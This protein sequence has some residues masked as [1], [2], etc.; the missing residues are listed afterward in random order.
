MR[1]THL[2]LTHFRSFSRLDL[3]LPIGATVIWGDN[4]A[5]K[6]NLIEALYL[7]ATSRSPYTSAEREMI[8][9][10]CPHRPAFA[11]VVGQVLR[12][13][14]VTSLEV[15]TAETD[16]S[17]S[18]AEF[19]PSP[20]PG[21]Y[22]PATVRR[23]VVING[24]P[25]QTGELLG[26]LNAV[27]FSPEE[28]ELV[29]G[30]AERRRR[31]LDIALS[32]LDRQYVRTLRQYQRVLVQRNALLRHL[33]D[34]ERAGPSQL[35]H[36]DTQAVSLGAA[37]VAARLRAVARL[38]IHLALMDGIA[39]GA[40]PI[41]I[42]YVS[43]VGFPNPAEGDAPLVQS[44]DVGD[45]LAEDV[46]CRLRVAFA[47][48]R[49]RE[50]AAAITLVGPHRDDLVVCAGA[51]DQRTY[52]SRGQQRTA[53]LALKIAEAGLMREVTGEPPVLLLDDVMSELDP[54]RRAFIESLCADA[55]QAIVTGTEAAVFTSAFRERSHTLR[56]DGAKFH[57]T[58]SG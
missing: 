19:E 29:A 53:A 55:D 57:S 25:R 44:I 37:I 7:L 52:G 43:G 14:R 12:E 56:L 1:V 54:T 33:R 39:L 16:A 27:H 22:R 21:M 35:D 20:D 4:G 26:H 51:V 41:R 36:W 9:W 13:G 47:R 38:N 5:G 11:R 31:F 42:T 10:H 49:T 17:A 2:A 28:V 18:P 6:S 46:A 58:P 50:R 8:G 3:S 45:T 48:Q 23:K 24:T 34:N 32:Q 30:S 15:L 40:A